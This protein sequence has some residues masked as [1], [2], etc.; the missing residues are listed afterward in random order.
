[1]RRAL[2]TMALA[3]AAASS[4][5]AQALDP[6]VDRLTASWSRGDAGGIVAFAAS[7]GLSLDVA[8]QRVGPL[9]PRQAAAVLRKLFEVAETVNTRVAM[10][11]VTGGAPRRAFIEITWT[12]RVRGTTIPQ[13]ST[14]FLGL[15]Q[16]GER[17]RLTEIRHLQ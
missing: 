15:V 2:I 12:T 13:R 6:V 7:R 8:G 10:A 4:V 3:L 1:M 9:P 5:A 17:W 14:V 11:K 16:E